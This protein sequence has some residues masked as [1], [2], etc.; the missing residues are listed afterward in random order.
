MT[1]G[2]V[3]AVAVT[4][5][6]AWQAGVVEAQVRVII[7][8]G[9]IE[10]LGNG[11]VAEPREQR[12]LGRDLLQGAV[13][14][15]PVEP[16]AETATAAIGDPWWDAAVE[17][18][19]AS[20][21]ADQPIGLNVPMRNMAQQRIEMQRRGQA[22]DHLRREL[23]LLRGACPKLT[24]HAR[25][26]IVAA[27]RAAV[28]REVQAGTR[29]GTRA[30]GGVEAVVEQMVA[31]QAGPADLAAYRRELVARDRRRRDAGVAVLT[32]AVDQEALLNP[33]Q[34][35]EVAAALAD[36]WQPAW[37]QVLLLATRQR[38]SGSRLPAGVE[39]VVAEVLDAESFA[40]WRERLGP[41]PP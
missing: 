1:S 3:T 16:P 26:E 34:R 10:V 23:S 22:L 17:K 28:E 2:T 39:D 8:G 19:T 30:T 14:R 32:E 12:Q 13:A 38:V 25:A 36:N 7:E 9:E 33:R 21:G 29:A 31:I 40:S 35:E 41:V 11:Q 15:L 20:G 27:G 18:P 5:A 6:T 24:P 4:L 37:D